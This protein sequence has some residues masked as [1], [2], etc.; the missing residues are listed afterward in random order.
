MKSLISITAAAVLSCF[1]ALGSAQ[2]AEMM[3][4]HA[5]KGVTCE[6]CHKTNSPSRAAKASSCA[7]CHTYAD[8][9]KKTSKMNPNPH[10]SHA[11]EVRC[12]LCHREHK[13][14]VNYCLECHQTGEKF[15]FK[16]P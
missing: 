3:M 12:T 2:A 1:I 10:E 13:A 7:R 15:Q 14:S 8:V 6:A 4:K 16:V 5:A 9:A 11:G